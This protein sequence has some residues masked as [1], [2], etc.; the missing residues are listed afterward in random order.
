MCIHSPHDHSAVGHDDEDDFIQDKAAS[1]R[2]A[3]SP[4]RRTPT[5]PAAKSP[6]PQQDP[7][8]PPPPPPILTPA[9]SSAPIGPSRNKRPTAHKDWSNLCQRNKLWSWRSR[10]WPSFC[11]R[12][13][14]KNLRLQWSQMCKCSYKNQSCRTSKAREVIPIVSSLK[15]EAS[16]AGYARREACR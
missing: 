15:I 6:P 12:I 7:T 2:L 16:G 1:P 9:A 14:M 3:V 11:T 13:L 8:T 4:P 5:P 10:R